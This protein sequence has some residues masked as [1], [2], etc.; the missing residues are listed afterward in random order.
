MRGQIGKPR[1]E[2]AELRRNCLSI[3]FK[4][5]EHQAVTEAAWRQRMT[6]SGWLRELA[7]EHLRQL[8]NPAEAER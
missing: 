3:R 7:L 4:D 8:S 6:A 2:E 1:F 5:C